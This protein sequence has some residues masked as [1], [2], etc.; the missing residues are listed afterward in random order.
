MSEITTFTTVL[1]LQTL[2]KGNIKSVSILPFLISI[3]CIPSVVRQN[4]PWGLSDPN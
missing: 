1:I 3:L 4:A 2:R